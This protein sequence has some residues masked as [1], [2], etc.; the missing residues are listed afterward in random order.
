MSNERARA[1]QRAMPA[2]CALAG[3][4]G[5]GRRAACSR[6]RTV[7]RPRDARLLAKRPSGA[8][9][10]EDALQCGFF[11][12]GA[13][14]P[15]R[16]SGRA[17]AVGGLMGSLS[18]ARGRGCQHG[19][20]SRSTDVARKPEGP[21][22]RVEVSRDGVIPSIRVSVDATFGRSSAVRPNRSVCTI[23]PLR[24]DRDRLARLGKSSELEFARCRET[25][26]GFA[27]RTNRLGLSG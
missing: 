21:R 7:Q 11:T 13:A 6:R 5:P 27:G 22:P 8:F 10:A 16:W 26:R 25:G 18:T 24:Q 15:R 12:P 20:G 14:R 19:R 23:E 1:V 3:G 17:G 9:M 4:V 2:R